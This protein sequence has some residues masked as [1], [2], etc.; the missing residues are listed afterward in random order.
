MIEECP[1][2]DVAQWRRA[3]ARDR[4]ALV[5]TRDTRWFRYGDLACAGL[6]MLKGGARIKG[7]YVTP[8]ARG[9]G[10]GT[11]LTEF[12]I[13]LTRSLGLGFVE[14]YAWN[15]GFYTDRRFAV[16]GRNAFGATKVRRRFQ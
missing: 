9:K 8:E 13:E 3:A 5:D 6:L 10:I 2:N 4:V 12:L 16:I 1:Y 14:A 7:V 11:S 15:P